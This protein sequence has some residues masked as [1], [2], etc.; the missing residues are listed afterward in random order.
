[1][2]AAALT[3]FLAPS[4]SLL[5]PAAAPPPVQ[6]CPTVAFH[7]RRWV[8]RSAACGR[9][10]SRRPLSRQRHSPRQ[11]LTLFAQSS[12]QLFLCAHALH[13]VLEL[14]AATSHAAKMAGCCRADSS[15]HSGTVRLVSSACFQ[16]LFDSGRA[17][18]AWGVQI[19]WNVCSSCTVP[20]CAGRSYEKERSVVQGSIGCRAHLWEWRGTQGECLCRRECSPLQSQN[21]TA[22]LLDS[23][24]GEIGQQIAPFGNRNVYGSLV[25]NTRNLSDCMRVLK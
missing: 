18:L 2:E 16:V 17:S 10:R 22:T 13:P 21:Q 25:S 8:A 20:P 23:R 6:A 1:M 3:P 5:P 24:R 9:P 11:E 19:S 12:G 4:P 7:R 14:S 15:H